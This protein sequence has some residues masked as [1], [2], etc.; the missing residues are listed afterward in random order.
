MF[1]KGLIILNTKRIMLLLLAFV[2][3][4]QSAFVCVVIS[5]DAD[6]LDVFQLSE[7]QVRCTFAD[8]PKNSWYYPYVAY[9]QSLGLVQGKTATQFFPK[10]NITT[11]E[12]IVI[13][14]RIYEI[15]HNIPSSPSTTD[16]VWYKPYTDRA[17]QY[18]LVPPGCNDYTKPILRDQAAAVFYRLLP[19]SDMAE[20]NNVNYLPDVD[21]TNPYF[22]EILTLYRVGVFS[23]SNPEGTFLPKNEITRA[24]LTK[25]AC[26]LINPNLR[27][28]KHFS[29][30]SIFM[31]RIQPDAVCS[32]TDVTKGSW[33]YT[34]VALQEQLGILSGMGNGI[35]HPTGTVTY[36]QAL[37]AAVEV[38]ER[39]YNISDTTPVAGRHWYDPYV[40]KALRYGIIVNPRE[41]YNE[42]A[43]RGD[44]AVFLYRSIHSCEFPKLNEIASIPDLPNTS[45]YYPT[46]LKL[47]EAGILRGTDQ[48]GNANVYQQI[49]RAE[50]ATMLTRLLLPLY[51]EVSPVNDDSKTLTY[52][53]SGSGKY[54]LTAISLGSGKNVLV[55]SFAI[56]GWQDGWERDGEELVALAD[57]LKQ[58]LLKNAALLQNGDWT[59]YILPC[60]NPDGLYDGS[61]HNGPGRCTTTCFD[62]S[63][64]LVTGKGMDLNRCFPYKFTPS[65]NPRYY[66]GTAPL[67]C[68]EARA[69]SSFMQSVKGSGVNIHIDVQ[70]WDGQLLTSSENSPVCQALKEQFPDSE[71]KNLANGS[72]YF[73][74]WTS[75]T[76]G[77]QSCLLSLPYT[78]T[79]HRSFIDSLS[80]DRLKLAVKAILTK[81]TK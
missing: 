25:I 39:Y 21:R 15:Y 64:K 63:G 4:M 45:F 30:L 6:G 49:S 16:T 17:E 59:V 46:I 54:P 55:L 67:Q 61:S 77:Y 57:A 40:E 72:G 52:G 38:Y 24:E 9:G 43:I 75:Y 58:E 73:S 29:N 50:L 71:I 80:T 56:H 70:G 7:D 2:I 12:A 18:G 48:A 10:A 11:A 26:A 47:Y 74:A 33:Y 51:R 81:A 41:N 37:K 53:N 34:Y 32:F 65:S 3:L 69:L 1:T 35:Y 27:S 23:G 8:V 68:A 28:K 78:I 60:L 79:D 20:V 14:V 31:D 62:D 44:I 76:L 19:K 42:P 66:N 5:A 13:G 22:N 36:A